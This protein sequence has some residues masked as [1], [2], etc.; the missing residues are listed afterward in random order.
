MVLTWGQDHKG[1]RRGGVSV[2][3]ILLVFLMFIMIFVF[4]SVSCFFN[5]CVLIKVSN[6]FLTWFNEPVKYDIDLDLLIWSWNFHSCLLLVF[7]SEKLSSFFFYLTF[8][9]FRCKFFIFT[10]FT[11]TIIVVLKNKSIKFKNSYKT[12]QI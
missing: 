7:I 3:W 10:F 9:F 6:L 11:S 2:L 4:I 5:N 12:E 8:F 1:H